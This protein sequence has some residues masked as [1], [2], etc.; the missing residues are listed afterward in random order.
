MATFRSLIEAEP[1]FAPALNYLGYMWAER[2]E[3]LEAALD[4]V[5]RAVALDP[6][7][8]AYVD[9][10][11]WA[12]FQ[13]GRLVE[14]RSHLERASRLIPDDATILEHLGDAQVAAGDRAAG[15]E[16][17]RRAAALGGD[18]L[19]AVQKKLADLE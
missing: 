12:Y 18:N 10:L 13:L 8:G 19:R 1:D 16:S 11:G 3:N 9:S 4:L 5:R 14:A 2:G 17:Y 7:N 6:D 15:R